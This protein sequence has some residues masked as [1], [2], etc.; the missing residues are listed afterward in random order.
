MCMHV[1]CACGCAR[2]CTASRRLTSH[3]PQ[4]PR[5]QGLGQRALCVVCC[6]CRVRLSFCQSHAKESGML[7]NDQFQDTGDMH[8]ARGDGE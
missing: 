3:A 7:Q 2:V 6:V 1:Q 5:G 4:R 8:G